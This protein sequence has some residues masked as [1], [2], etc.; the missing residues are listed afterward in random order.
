MTRVTSAER[1]ESIETLRKSVKPGDTLHTIVRHVARSGM[2][3]SIDVYKFSIA[4]KKHGHAP[5]GVCKEWLTF[6][7]GRALG[8]SMNKKHEALDV[9]G[10][11]MDMGFHLVYSL[12]SALFSKDGYECLGDGCPSNWH[13]GENY[14]KRCKE[15]HRDGYALRQEWI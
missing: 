3:R 6:H 1:L 13:S 2:S 14:G 8:Y 15:P 10:C 5:N 12:A 11:G 4:D 7:V 9:G